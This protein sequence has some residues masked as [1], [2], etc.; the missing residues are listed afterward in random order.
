MYISDE[1]TGQDK[2]TCPELGQSLHYKTITYQVNGPV[3]T[4]YC[5]DLY[6]FC[7]QAAGLC[8]WS[9]VPNINKSL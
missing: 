6:H 9:N 7:F 3:R 8:A 2:K 1:Q 4:D 5:G